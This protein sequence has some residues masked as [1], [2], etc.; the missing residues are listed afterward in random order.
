[1]DGKGW[2]L[3]TIAEVWCGAVVQGWEGN[4]L[5]FQLWLGKSEERVCFDVGRKQ[6]GEFECWLTMF[7]L[8]PHYLMK[9]RLLFIL[10]LLFQMLDILQ[11][12]ISHHQNILLLLLFVC[13]FVFWVA[14]ISEIIRYLSS[15]LTSLSL[16]LPRSIHVVANGKISFLFMAK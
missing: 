9:Y 2:E 4:R 15:C 1:M 16:I 10:L 5:W 12:F 13:S 7:L 8:L 14:N 3:G 6:K 11:C